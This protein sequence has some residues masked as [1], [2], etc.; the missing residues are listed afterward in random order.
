MVIQICILVYHFKLYVRPN[1]I[2]DLVQIIDINL[3]KRYVS[4]QHNPAD[5]LRLNRSLKLL[6]GILKEIGS[7]KLPNGMMAMAQ[8]SYS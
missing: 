2:N 4:M 1:L 3:Q 7:I 5:T 8:V 6:N